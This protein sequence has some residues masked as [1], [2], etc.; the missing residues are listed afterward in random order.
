MAAFNVEQFQEKS[1]YL[2]GTDMYYDGLYYNLE[3]ASTILDKKTTLSEWG[4]MSLMGRF[5]YT[6]LDRYLLTLTYRYDGSSRLSDKNKWAGFP[7]MSVAWR[8]SEEAFLQGARSR[9]LDNLKLRFSWG[10]TGNTNVDPYETLGKLSKTYYSWNETAAIG[11][12]PT[13]IPNPDLK[14]EKTEEYNVGL[15]FSLFNS[16]LNGTIDWYQRTTKDLILKRQLPV[17]SGFSEIYQNIGSTRNKGV[18]LTLN[19]CLLYTSPSPRD[20]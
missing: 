8:L 7:S 16:R 4:I 1:V 9:F 12:I 19:G 18:E 5:N 11:T 3:A 6:L 15:D 20:S 2:K 13:G 10:N 17:T 14:W